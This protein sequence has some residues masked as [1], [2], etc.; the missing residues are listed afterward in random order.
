MTRIATLRWISFGSVLALVA[1]WSVVSWLDLRG[2]TRCP[3]H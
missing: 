2:R 1:V 3:V